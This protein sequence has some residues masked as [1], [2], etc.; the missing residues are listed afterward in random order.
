MPNRSRSRSPKRRRK[1]F[2]LKIVDL[3]IKSGQLTLGE[4]LPLYATSKAFQPFFKEFW[5]RAITLYGAHYLF[6]IA[7]VEMWNL[8]RL[9]T[10]QD[11]KD[12]VG[13]SNPQE[14]F[15]CYVSVNLAGI[16]KVFPQFDPFDS[17]QFIFYDFLCKTMKFRSEVGLRALLRK[18]E[19]PCCTILYKD[20]AFL[21]RRFYID[22]IV[23]AEDYAVR[24]GNKTAIEIMDWFYQDYDKEKVEFTSPIP[25]LP[26]GLEYEL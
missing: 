3:L 13:L 17:D 18:M 22:M 24:W 11:D 19:E 5:L 7:T 8:V 6:Y 20:Y 1:P 16:T 2:D 21:W 10:A 26:A 15:N 23:D 14:R 12:Y 9:V 25:P 4:L